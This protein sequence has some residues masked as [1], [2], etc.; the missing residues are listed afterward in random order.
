MT[1]HGRFGRQYRVSTDGRSWKPASSYP[2]LFEPAGE[3]K[4]KK[5]SVVGSV[6]T[7]VMRDNSAS[8]T[9]PATPVG[10]KWFYSHDGQQFG[11]VTM[12]ILTHCRDTATLNR[13]D[14]VW[15]T[16]MAE[17]KPASEALPNLFADNDPVFATARDNSPNVASHSSDRILT[18]I[19]AV[20]VIV[21]ATVGVFYGFA[22][23][24]QDASI[25]TPS[26]SY[27]RTVSPDSE[28]MTE[29]YRRDITD[30]M[31][32]QGA[33]PAEAEVFTKTLNDLQREWEI[34]N[35]NR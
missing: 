27:R 35:R 17:W 28:V 25:A 18:V 1:T 14:L 2:E 21:I 13:D 3:P 9:P 12:E 24:P 30:Q 7:S 15:T 8:P 31:V 6:G 4:R 32:L 11:P 22:V 19:A 10:A 33:D 26:Q 34:E 29:E 20:F 16:G 5:E 23:G